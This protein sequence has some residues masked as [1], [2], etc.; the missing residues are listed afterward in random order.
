MPWKVHVIC[1]VGKPSAEHDKF[2]AVPLSASTLC[3]PE[4]NRGATKQEHY[5]IDSVFVKK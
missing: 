5:S 2:T 4:I 1:G 3:S